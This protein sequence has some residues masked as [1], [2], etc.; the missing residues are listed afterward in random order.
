VSFDEV[1]QMRFSLLALALSVASLCSLGSGA[2]A[3]SK[4]Q[5]GYIATGEGIRYKKVA[6]INVKVYDITSY[7]K[8]TPS[9]KS[10]EGMISLDADKKLSWKMLRTVD[11]D[12]IRNALR[13]AYAKNGYADK[14]KI[15]QLLGPITG[16]LKD[17][18]AV[19]I[20]YD[21][22]KKVTTLSVDNRTASV[23]GA[24]FMKATWSIWF[25]NIDQP[26]LSE[27]LV[28]KLK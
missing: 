24:E 22:A 11:A 27:Q 20:R 3:Q 28:S 12:K 19:S 25:G 16:D 7:V 6:F 26:A 17:G 1:N 13:E 5:D 2:F 14:G 8:E 9:S 4:D 21:A 15:E 23:E 10:K 18:Q